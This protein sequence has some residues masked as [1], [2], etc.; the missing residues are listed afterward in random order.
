MIGSAVLS[1]SPLNRPEDVIRYVTPDMLELKTATNSILSAQWRW[2]YSD[3]DALREWVAKQISYKNDQAVYGV[4]DYWQ[5][6]IETLERGAGDCEDHAIL[7]CSMLR[8]SG[9][10]PDEVYVAIGNI[11]GTDRYHAYLFER[12]TRGIW[13]VID[14]QIDMSTSVLTLELIDWLLTCD[15]SND[16]YCFND[17]YFFT[18]PPVLG[19]GVYETEVPFGFWPLANAAS[20]KFERQLGAEEKVEGL[21]EWLGTDKI[22]MNWSLAAYS[23]DGAPVL[24]WSGKDK[25]HEFI[26]LATIPGIYRFEILKRDT[27]ARCIRLT[28]DPPDWEKV[29]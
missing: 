2:A 16:I 1:R 13:R 9:V 29:D 8:A 23:P 25:R 14:P 21:V 4:S 22:I 17:Q 15:Y 11:K 28:I 6:P 5:L 7:L 12:F 19:T 20:V 27:I 18:G 10:P 24:A 3:F 26:L